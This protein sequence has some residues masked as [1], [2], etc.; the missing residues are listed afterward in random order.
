MVRVP[1]LFHDYTR[2]YFV[3]VGAS[4]R[5]NGCQND[6]PMGARNKPKLNLRKRKSEKMP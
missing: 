6:V 3:P 4:T 5:A 1:F 2:K